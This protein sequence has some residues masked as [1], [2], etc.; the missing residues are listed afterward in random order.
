[1]IGHQHA[2]NVP[3]RSAW[4][5]IASVSARAATPGSVLVATVVR[6]VRTED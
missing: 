5:G 6:Q 3:R 4:L 2:H 1:V